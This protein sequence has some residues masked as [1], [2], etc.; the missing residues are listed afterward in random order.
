MG[1][2]I[3][4]PLTPGQ[5]WAT[6]PTFDEITK[7]APE[8]K[9]TQIKRKTGG[10]NA[11]GHVTSRHRGGGHKQRYRFIDFKRDKRDAQG[12]VIAFEYD[13]NRTARIALVE[14]PDQ[15]RRYIL[16]PVGLSLGDEIMASAE[17]EARIGNALPLRSIP[18]GTVVHNV[19]LKIG[20]GG[21][22]ARSAGS[23]VQV[24]AKEGDYAHLRLPSGEVRLVHVDC[25][26]SVGQIGNIEHETLSLGKAGRSRWMGIRPS[27]RGVAMNP[28]DHPMGGGEGKTSGGRHPCSPTGL[29]SKGL[30]TRKKHHSTNR[31]IIKR[32][33]SNK[34]KKGQQVGA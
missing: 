4:R 22:I 17:G 30:R 1:I 25:W 32:R 3:L 10:R 33:P 13:P 28:H 16:A 21:Q 8:K 11:Y 20:K 6:Y 12:K 26:A 7:K 19:E 24:M 31:Y 5:R 15:E 34:K 23:A 14:Y 27:V 9:L 2:R 29:K 18:V